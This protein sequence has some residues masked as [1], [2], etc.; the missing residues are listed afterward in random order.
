MSRKFIW[1][2]IGIMTITLVGLIVLQTYWI[3]NAVEVKNDQFDQMVNK[4]MDHISHQ[5]ETQEVLLEISSEISSDMPNELLN[6]GNEML[7]LNK[8]ELNEQFDVNISLG[9]EILMIQKG[10]SLD[11][12]TKFTVYSGDSLIY[13]KDNNTK[14][15]DSFDEEIKDIYSRKELQTHF[16]KNVSNKADFVET[17]INKLM[18]T[19][20]SLDKRI[21]LESVDSI[22][23]VELNNVGIELPYEYSVFKDEVSSISSS[24]NYNPDSN[25]DIYSCRLFPNDILANPNHL[26]IY[27]PKK[28]RYITKS[29]LF[30]GGMSLT[31]TLVIIM[32]FT[33]T[34][35]II[36]RQR[37]L[38]EMKSDFVSNMT[39]ELKTPISTISLASQMLKDKSLSS[40][41]KN[42][43]NISRIIDEESKRLGYQVEKVLQVAIFEKGNMKLKISELDI[44]E[45]IKSAA[46]NFKIQISKRNGQLQQNLEA[47]KH[48][49]FADELHITN[50]IVNLLD[51]AVKYS[52]KNPEI[53]ISTH[54]DR[55]GIYVAIQDNG[56][57]ISR[58][59]LKR[60]FEKFYRV[61]TGNVQDVKGFGLGLS[62]VKKIIDAHSGKIKAESEINKGTKFEIILPYG[63][64]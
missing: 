51:N 43:D 53:S 24:E 12:N 60:I 21:K 32:A 64:E 4:A 57:G 37:R 7:Y 17:I 46:G 10:D 19:D 14:K 33:Y 20:R 18:N 40:D 5:I 23:N 54:D 49:I 48:H 35:Y 27:F 34:L 3:K 44:H 15:I 1:I 8:G 39:H 41:L 52:K 58:E 29:L 62:Y 47:E 30:I 59:N 6:N 28:Q 55:N 11:V 36:L 25:S 56:I 45:I 38:S 2:L 50:V 22:I 9:E 26:S 61:P 31:L 13:R 16:K 63:N 42:I